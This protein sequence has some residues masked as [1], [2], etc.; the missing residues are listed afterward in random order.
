MDNENRK[1]VNSELQNTFDGGLLSVES[2]QPDNLVELPSQEEINAQ[3]ASGG[4]T[5]NFNVNVNLSSTST[6]SLLQRNNAT[7][8]VNNVLG[9]N[10]PS[11]PEELKKNYTGDSKQDG[12]SNVKVVQYENSPLVLLQKSINSGPPQPTLDIRSLDYYSPDAP[13]DY[14]YSQSPVKSKNVDLKRSY[15]MLHTLTQNAISD[16]MQMS[17]NTSVIQNEFSNDLREININYLEKSNIMVDDSKPKMH[18]A[19]TDLS[20]DNEQKMA[21]R[22]KER[23]E[24]LTEMARNSTKKQDNELVFSEIK[25]GNDIS[26]NVISGARTTYASGVRNFNN[27]GSRSTTIDTFIDKMNSPPIWRTALG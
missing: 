17:P 18:D 27:I 19:V 1:L 23:D 14:S 20:K 3:E 25:N 9:N 4:V 16:R 8:I 2:S 6:P 12:D 13:S 10:P 11:S 24:S 7:N 21:M 22:E 15:D 5:N 26:G